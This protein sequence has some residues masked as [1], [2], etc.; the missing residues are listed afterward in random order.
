MAEVQRENFA[1]IAHR[2]NPMVL[3][4]G[5]GTILMVAVS[6]VMPPNMIFD[7]VRV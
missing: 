6:S 7:Q 4:E 3:T 1:A 2:L 5:P